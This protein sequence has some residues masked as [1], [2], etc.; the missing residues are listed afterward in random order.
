MSRMI[1]RVVRCALQWLAKEKPKNFACIEN[2]LVLFIPLLNNIWNYFSTKS[3]FKCSVRIL[4][5]INPFR[6]PLLS[7]KVFFQSC[8]KSLINLACSGP[9]WENIGPRSFL[10]G[11]RCV[12]CALSRS[13]AD[14]FPPSPLV[15]KMCISAHIR[16]V[17][18]GR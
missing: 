1:P 3:P 18:K 6:C 13:R 14:I 12:R 4:F 5:I 11:P 7:I 9:Y 10:C 16:R 17:L 2:S 8:N 15:N